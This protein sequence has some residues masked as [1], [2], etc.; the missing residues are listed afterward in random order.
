MPEMSEAVCV[1]CSHK[2]DA[3]ARVC[4]YCGANPQTGEK[5]DTEA[6]LRETFHPRTAQSRAEGVMEFARQRQGIVVLVGVVV[7]FLILA[8]L[9]QFVTA[10]NANAVASGPAVPLTD[11][12]DLSNQAAQ[13]QAQPMPKL[14]FRYDGNSK[15]MRTFIVESGAVAPPEV[16][17]AQQAAAQQA[18]VQKAAAANAAHPAPATR[19]TPAVKSTRPPTRP[20]APPR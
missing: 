20:P 6:L 14:D 15:T 5:I 3:A 18:A 2:I 16:I 8:A 1:A 12:T 13:V 17:A 9:H 4:P 19:P 7:A 11:I 10:R